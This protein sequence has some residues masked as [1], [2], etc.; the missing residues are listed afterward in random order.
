MHNMFHR[1]SLFHEIG[2][3]VVADYVN[4]EF[5]QTKF[6]ELGKSDCWFHELVNSFFTECVNSI[7]HNSMTLQI[8][9][10]KKVFSE[11]INT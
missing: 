7:T 3:N 10:K 5:W 6:T 4:L 8:E 2:S 9:K 1:I 11:I